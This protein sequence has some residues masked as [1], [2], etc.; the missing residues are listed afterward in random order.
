MGEELTMRRKSAA[1]I[2][3]DHGHSPLDYFKLWPD[4]SYFFS[5]WRLSPVSGMARRRH[6]RNASPASSTYTRRRCK[7]AC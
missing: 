7:A 4:K 6:C 2:V 3:Y 5:A 1:A